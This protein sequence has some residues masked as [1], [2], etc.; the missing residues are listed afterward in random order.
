[1]A[2]YAKKGSTRTDI[3]EAMFKELKKDG[4]DYYIGDVTVGDINTF[5]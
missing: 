1:M 5:S 3:L 4:A 2:R